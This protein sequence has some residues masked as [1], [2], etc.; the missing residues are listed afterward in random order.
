MKMPTTSASGRTRA[1]GTVTSR[2]TT[3]R[4]AKPKAAAARP[5]ATATKAKTKGTPS[6]KVSARATSK[7]RKTA[8]ARASASAK[9][10][11]GAAKTTTNHTKIQQWAESRRGVPATVKSTG[12]KKDPGVLRIDFPGFS[13][14]RSLKKISWDEWFDKFD[15]SRLAFLYQ[16]KT[17]DGKQSRFFK[18]V[19]K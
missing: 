5:K 1:K 12:S 18:L 17:K 16:D 4:T 19:K 2:K 14:A 10:V 8:T 6:S 9:Q 3:L 11:S 13:G 15:E 7:G